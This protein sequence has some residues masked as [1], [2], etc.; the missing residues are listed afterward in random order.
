MLY[1]NFA[2]L[3][4]STALLTPQDI[5]G[6][7]PD[8]LLPTTYNWSIG[9]QREIPLGMVIDIAYVGNVYKH[10]LTPRRTALN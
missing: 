8:H 4:G 7:S 9:I 1:S 5:Q 2:Q 3:A 6:G 10:G